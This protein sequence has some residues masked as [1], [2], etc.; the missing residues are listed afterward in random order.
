MT[1]DLTQIILGII[2]V[3]GGIVAR[4]LIPWIKSKLDDNQ[5]E[6]FCTLIRVGVYAAEQLF[7]R[8]K[9]KEKKQYVV[10]LLKENGYTVDTTAVDAMI[11]ATVRELRIEQGQVQKDEVSAD[12]Q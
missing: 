10:D 7:P 8:D 9:W 3:I 2:T 4:Y 5:Y 1:I 6:T 11:E 12:E